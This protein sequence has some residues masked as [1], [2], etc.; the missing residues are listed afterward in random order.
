MSRTAHRCALR[1]ADRL[2]VEQLV[3]EVA[4]LLPSPEDQRVLR[5]RLDQFLGLG[6][7]LVQGAMLADSR[8]DLGLARRLVARGCPVEIAARILL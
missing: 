3:K 2:G 6:F 4:D 1:H 8:V 5:W 7:D